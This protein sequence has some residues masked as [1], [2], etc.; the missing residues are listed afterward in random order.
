MPVIR[1]FFGLGLG[2]FALSAGILLEGGS[3]RTYAQFTPLLVVIGGTVGMCLMVF[4]P[5][6]LF[7]SFLFAM[8]IDPV[9]KKSRRLANHV[10]HVASKGLTYSGTVGFIFGLVHVLS[11]LSSMDKIGAGVACAIMAPLYAIVLKLFVIEPLLASPTVR[12]AL[13]TH[14]RKNRHQEKLEPGTSGDRLRLV[15]SRD[16][17]N[18]MR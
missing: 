7:H 4:T 9:H 11:N 8:G 16:G 1:S 6:E 13:A 14:A 2:V 3:L 10:F 12:H 15:K 18:L 5:F 17:R